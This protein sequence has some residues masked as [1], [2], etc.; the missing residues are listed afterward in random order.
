MKKTKTLSILGLGL[1][2]SGQALSSGDEVS[3]SIDVPQTLSISTPS[4]PATGDASSG[5]AMISTTWTVTS[6]NAFAI[7]F[8]GNSK[9]ESGATISFPQFTKEDVDANGA[10]KGT[11]DVL[12]TKFGVEVTEHDSTAVSPTWGGGATPTGEP[13]DLVKSLDASGSPDAAIGAIMPG[14]D[15]STAKVTLNAKADKDQFDQS[16][17][18]NM[19]VTI[20]ATAEEQ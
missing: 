6:N 4:D 8:D 20:T 9:D 2:V 18:Y 10:G 7:S 17:N 14:D 19:S 5:S 12:D 1:I 15:T 11:Y 3:N 16:G 13:A